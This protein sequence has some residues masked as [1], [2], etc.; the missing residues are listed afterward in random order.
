MRCAFRNKG[1]MCEKPP[2][3]GW[4]EIAAPWSGKSRP[5]Y[6]RLTLKCVHMFVPGAKTKVSAQNRQRSRVG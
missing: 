2:P 4:P 6:G 5:V 1:E 3:P